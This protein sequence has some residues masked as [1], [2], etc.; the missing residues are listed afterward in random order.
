MLISRRISKTV[1]NH[2]FIF[3]FNFQRKHQ[4]VSLISP[5]RRKNIVK[6]DCLFQVSVVSAILIL[7]AFREFFRLPSPQRSFFFI[8][9]YRLTAITIPS[10]APAAFTCS[11][12][13]TPYGV[14]KQTRSARENRRHDRRNRCDV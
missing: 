14:G 4:S 7:S 8:A 3:S 13:L 5:L 10:C 11:K 6:R 2:I 1:G 12:K 9:F